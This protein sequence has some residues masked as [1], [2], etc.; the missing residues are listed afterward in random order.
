MTASSSW[1]TKFAWNALVATVTFAVILLCVALLFPF[2]PEC[3]ALVFF[4]AYRAVPEALRDKARVLVA[5]VTAGVAMTIAAMGLIYARAGPDAFL[6]FAQLSIFSFWFDMEA[7][8]AAKR[9]E[10]YITVYPLI[11]NG[12]ALFFI[13]MVLQSLRENPK[14]I[15]VKF[16]GKDAFSAKIIL[17][18]VIPLMAIMKFSHVVYPLIDVIEEDEGYFI[19]PVADSFSGHYLIAFGLFCSTIALSGAMN[20]VIAAVINSHETFSRSRAQ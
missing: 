15:M 12:S 20:F 4:I 13:Y 9:G 3:A 8:L 10:P 14:D 7:F 5:S 2:G 16:K 11:I 17:I 6:L 19:A 1:A 18:F